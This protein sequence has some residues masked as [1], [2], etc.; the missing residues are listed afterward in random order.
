MRLAESDVLRFHPQ[1]KKFLEEIRGKGWSYSF[2][3]IVGEAEVEIDPER[4]TFTLHYYPP[5]I[6]V[7]EEEGKYTVEAEVGTEPPSV[8]R[9]LRVESFKVEIS[10]G[11][12][13]GAVK[14]DPLAKTVEHI[15]NV[16]GWSILEREKKRLAD[17]RAVYEVV[18]WL[19]KV[20]GFKLGNEWVVEKYKELVDMFEKPYRFE[21]K[22]ELTV[23][24]ESRVPS[25][26]DLLKDLCEF[27]LER[28]LLVKVSR[29]RGLFL[30]KP[31]P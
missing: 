25:W 16:L 29:N 4:L 15:T 9:V 21:L 18:K 27:F 17:A 28:G 19:V 7:L 24:D 2:T 26:E 5:R 1:V 8:I 30:R 20:K 31:I 6:D 3:D 22:L 12:Y 10:A 23:K 11:K 13:I 14:V